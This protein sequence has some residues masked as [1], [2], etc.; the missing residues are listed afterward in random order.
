MGLSFKV[1]KRLTRCAQ[2]AF[3]LLSGIEYACVLPTL[4]LYLSQLD[5]DAT[6]FGIVMSAYSLTGMLAAPL[7][8]LV[9]DRFRR[10]QLIILFS[11]LWP[12]GGSFLYFY[13]GSKY[14]LL[15]SRLISGVGAGAFGAIYADI[16]RSTTEK[17][18]AAVMSGTGL[19]R[20]IGI[21]FGPAVNIPLNSCDFYIGPLHVNKFS[22][23]GLI[24][25]ILFTIL[26]IVTLFCYY[27]VPR[28][29]EEMEARNGDGKPDPVEDDAGTRL[30][31]HDRSPSPKD[32]G[33]AGDAPKSTEAVSICGCEEPKQLKRLDALLREE[34]VVVLTASFVFFF[35]QYCLETGLTVMTRRLLQFGG[36]ENSIMFTLAAA[37]LIISFL[38]VNFVSKIISDRVMLITSSIV[39][40]LPFI[41]LM[42]FYPNAVP[43]RDK[44]LW[45]F[46]SLSVVLMAAL[47]YVYI[48]TVALF[49]KVTPVATQGFMQGIRQAVTGVGTIMGPLW[50]G[51]L[52][53]WPF[54]A[55]AVMVAFYFLLLIMITL[56][57]KCLKPHSDTAA[58]RRVPVSD[59]IDETK[60]LLTETDF[61][62]YG[63]S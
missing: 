50:A 25:F 16:S 53:H 31:G 23:P 2:F 10:T 7:Y 15:G 19:F 62:D 27:D 3:F 52:E 37:L 1:K 48:S 60:P 4:N 30:N 41:L 58:A 63:V 42:V 29:R 9:Q 38:S 34:V 24:M 20:Q 14:V 46:A 56:S 55:L 51:T 28:L 33:R 40:S 35:N 22:G 57:W 45:W 6:F 61:S 32:R 47:P 44:N 26:E 49:S 59:E 13:G 39:E 5:G 8:G 21:L 18:R 17:E 54:E 12:I 36:V 43:G 11:I